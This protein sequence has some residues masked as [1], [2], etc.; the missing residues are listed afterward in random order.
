M[1]PFKKKQTEHTLKPLKTERL[2]IKSRLNA[3]PKKYIGKAALVY[4]GKPMREFPVE[5]K[6]YSRD[7]VA[8]KLQDGFE[9]K[10]ISLH[11]VKAK[12]ES[13]HK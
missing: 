5:A 7:E 12:R 13:K 8:K 1:W 11:Q 2:G 9:V 4:N 3:K 6:G 10:L